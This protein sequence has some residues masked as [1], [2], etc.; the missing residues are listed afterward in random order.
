M[1]CNI[2]SFNLGGAVCHY[3]RLMKDAKHDIA[4]T[5][6]APDF[7][8]GGQIIYD[9]ARCG[10]FTRKAAAVSGSGPSTT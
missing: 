7:V 8:G 9:A 2:C 6:P 5:M 1:A 3:H 4:T 10:K